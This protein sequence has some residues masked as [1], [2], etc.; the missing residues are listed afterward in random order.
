MRKKTCL[1]RAIVQSCCIKV[2]H[3]L[4]QQARHRAVDAGQ[5]LSGWVSH[6]IEREVRS[7][8]SQTPRSLLE[9]LG[10]DELAEVEL[11]IKRDP[12]ALLVRAGLAH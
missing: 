5:S 2:D 4:A 7:A 11:D 3:D 12:E 9:A 8:A 1:P 10:R 6:L